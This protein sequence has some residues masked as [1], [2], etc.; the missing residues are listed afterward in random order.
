[1]AERGGLAQF[2]AVRYL[3]A[4]LGDDVYVAALRKF[5]R[6]TVKKSKWG[7]I[8]MGSRLSYLDFDAYQAIVY[9]KSALVLVL[10][11]DLVGE[12]TFFRGLREFF[13][14]FKFKTART[15]N[16]RAV[17]ERASGRDLKA[18]FDLWFGSHLLPEAMVAATARK[19][20]EGFVLQVR[21]TQKG[22]A[23]VFPCG[24]SGRRAAGGCA[25]C[26]SSTPRSRNSTPP[27]PP[28]R[29]ASRST[30]TSSCPGRSISCTPREYFA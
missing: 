17:M 1:M 30:R 10:L 14:A 8:A 15:V 21:V 2:S 4:K 20:G 18:F 19:E 12:E 22:P 11:M 24:W 23:F 6:W 16:F 26:S 3:K 5:S 7:P 29:P 27:A 28:A 25:G 9:N 13:A